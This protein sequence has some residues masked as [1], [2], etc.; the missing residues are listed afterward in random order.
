MDNTEEI[1]LNKVKFYNNSASL[2]GGAIFIT[3]QNSD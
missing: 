2:D 3:G 1:H